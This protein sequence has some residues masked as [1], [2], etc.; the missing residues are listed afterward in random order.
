[1]ITI[2][3]LLF[4]GLFCGMVFC[5]ALSGCEVSPDKAFSVSSSKYS[6]STDVVEVLRGK[7]SFPVT[8]YGPPTPD[9][10]G[11]DGEI[12]VTVSGG[13]NLGILNGQ[14][15]V[16]YSGDYSDVKEFTV[17][18]IPACGYITVMFVTNSRTEPAKY[19]ITAHFPNGKS[20]YVKVKV[21]RYFGELDNKE[22]VT[23]PIE[24]PAVRP[25]TAAPTA[26]P[27]V[28][29]ENSSSQAVLVIVPTQ[30]VPESTSAK[31]PAGF[32][33][34]CAALGCAALLFRRV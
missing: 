11:A 12:R 33:G 13:E 28:S 17:T 16:S 21:V 4:C 23:E 14:L 32:A 20:D 1:M 6:V 9:S 24:V 10:A 30:A 5:S 15:Y 29:D 18:K 25:R 31:S 26:V 3:L 22:V 34:L 7:S 8:I 2:G 27:T 19:K